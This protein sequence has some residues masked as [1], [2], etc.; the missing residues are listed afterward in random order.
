MS[1]TASVVIPQNKM[2]KKF[3]PNFSHLP[4][5]ILL[6]LPGSGKRMLGNR[7]RQLKDYSYISVGQILR[8]HKI[9]HPSIM[10]YATAPE[11]APKDVVTDIIKHEMTA[12]AS[13]N[14]EYLLQGFPISTDQYVWFE[15]QLGGSVHLAILLDIPVQ[16]AIER[17]ARRKLCG[18]RWD[19]NFNVA[20]ERIKIFERLTEPL[21]EHL[22]TTGKL[23]RICGMR[24]PQ[25]IC[26]EV[27]H[28]VIKSLQTFA[29]K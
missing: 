1:T 19:D 18:S 9:E 11:L 26:D 27:L 7:L 10:G 28:K 20:L 4:T 13:K 8:E 25:D 21:L 14:R 15:K 2:H 5:I 6:G 3:K 24:D 12:R 22:D 17:T 29:R 16:C 23:L